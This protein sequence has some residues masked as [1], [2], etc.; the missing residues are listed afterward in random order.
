MRQRIILPRRLQAS[1]HPVG[2]L[3]PFAAGTAPLNGVEA[4]VEAAADVRLSCH[5]CGRQPQHP[6]P[7]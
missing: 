7:P 5:L 6:G 2:S 1:A 3:E 4:L